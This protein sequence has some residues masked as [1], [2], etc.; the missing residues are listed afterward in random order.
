MN[1]TEAVKSLMALQSKLSAYSHAMSVL[2]FDGETVAPKGSAEN[3][4]HT[5][6]ELSGAVYELSTCKET[7]ELLEYLDAN[8]SQLSEKEQRMVELMIKDIRTMEKIPMD[9][10]I[11]HSALLSKANAVWH[12]AKEKSDFALF[13]PYL[14]QIFADAKKFAGYCAPEKKPYDYWLGEFEDGL[15]MEKCEEFFGALRERLV[16]LIKAIS[17]K[18]Q[19]DDSVIKGSF[20][21]EK[22][23]ELSHWI[24][25]VIGLDPD[26]CILGTVEH[27]FTD[28]MGS[29][30]DVRI[31]TKYIPTDYSNSMF[32]VVH[33]GGH[34][35]YESG[36]AD[37]LAYTV[38]DGGVSMGIHESQSRFY[39]NIIGRSRE[40]TALVWPKLTE[41]W[42]E[43]SKYSAEDFYKAV[44]KVQP[45]LIRTEADQ[46]TYS[47]H[48]MVRYELE[49][50]IMAGEL[51][52]H[53]LPSEW[54]RL[55]K[56]YLGVDVPNDR[57]GVLQ[58]THWSGG[59]IG[60][61]PSYAL[62]SAYGAQFLK[63]M[64]ETVNVEECLAKG[65]LGPINEW[66]RTQIWQYGQLYKP[67]Q[68]LE[69]VLGEDFDPKYYLDYLEAACKDVYGL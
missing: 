31:T 37:D 54:N 49:K 53:E 40:F 22:Q 25:G 27:P 7:V 3:R 34:A 62:G 16:P 5:M 60:Y 69:R 64:K 58:D 21:D 32:S 13:E 4:A 67:G 56:E 57:L 14:E 12:E 29:H 15:T 23:E 48:I 51:T 41:L 63:K 45:S 65:D 39:E 44:N 42:P 46:V 19:V 52:V 6:G 26:H 28:S 24:M 59:S 61:F 17:E 35:L 38:L 55:Y 30:H 10:Y 20:S 9:E 43:L 50:R 36:S 11:A 2:N 33:E 47:L 66:N 8:K 68:V 1:V 18:P